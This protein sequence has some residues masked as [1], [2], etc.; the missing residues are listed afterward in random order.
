MPSPL[1]QH[2]AERFASDARALRAR[3]S[4]L[5]AAGPAAAGGPGRP[6]GRKAPPARPA[7]PSVESTERMARA[8]DQVEAMFAAVESDEAA[9]ALLPT[10]SGLVAGARTED[11]RYVYAG[12]VARLTDALDGEDDDE[13]D[14]DDTEGDDADEDDA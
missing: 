2:L 8:C 10:L 13:E 4:A 1:A 12:A 7:G 9:S 14:G 5:A 11:E 3:A 6:G